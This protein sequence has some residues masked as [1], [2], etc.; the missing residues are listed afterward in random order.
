MPNGRNGAFTIAQISDIHCG[1]QYFV[2]NLME[3]AITE[4]NELGV[5]IG[6]CPLTCIYVSSYRCS[7]G[8]P[9]QSFDYFWTADVPSVDDVVGPSE[10]LDRLG[11]Q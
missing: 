8:N 1:G 5:R 11:A 4:I 9:S 2:P 3:R 10:L 7:R 6:R